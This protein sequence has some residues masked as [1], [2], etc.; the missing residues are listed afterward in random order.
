MFREWQASGDLRYRCE[1]DGA[2]GAGTDRQTALMAMLSASDRI[3]A[4]CRDNRTAAAHIL[5]HY[6][7]NSLWRVLVH[8]LDTA[9]QGCAICRES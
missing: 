9:C 3:P 1:L 8:I 7:V 4:G 6:E 2:Q 5:W